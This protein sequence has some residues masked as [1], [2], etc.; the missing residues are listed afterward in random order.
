MKNIL[1]ISFLMALA[2]FCQGVSFVYGMD[3]A[4]GTENKALIAPVKDRDGKSVAK[5][6]EA[7]L[8]DAS[9]LVGIGVPEQ[10]P[11][12]PLNLALV[13]TDSSASVPAGSDGSARTTRSG[14]LLNSTRQQR[15]SVSQTLQTPKGENSGSQEGEVTAG[16]DF[17][18]MAE[19]NRLVAQNGHNGVQVT[20]TQ[21]ATQQ[22][23]DYNSD[24]WRRE[25]DS[26]RKKTRATVRDFFTEDGG[27]VTAGSENKASTALD[28][29]RGQQVRLLAIPEDSQ[30]TSPN[31]QRK[32]RR[33]THH[34]RRTPVAGAQQ[35]TQEVKMIALQDCPPPMSLEEICKHIR[36]QGQPKTQYACL[37]QAKNF[38]TIVLG[39]GQLKN[40]QGSMQLPQ[41]ALQALAIELAV[42]GEHSAQKLFDKAMIRLYL[43]YHLKYAV[44]KHMNQRGNNLALQP[45][46]I[47]RDMVDQIAGTQYQFQQLKF[48][49][50]DKAL[51]PC[52]IHVNSPKNACFHYIEGFKQQLPILLRDLGISVPLARLIINYI[53]G[54]NSDDQV[55]DILEAHYTCGNGPKINA[56]CAGKL[57]C[58][59]PFRL[60]D[61]KYAAEPDFAL[62]DIFCMQSGQLLQRLDEMIADKEE[63]VIS[64]GD[65][66]NLLSDVQ[67]VLTASKVL[68]EAFKNDENREVYDKKEAQ[69]KNS[70]DLVKYLPKAYQLFNAQLRHSSVWK[71]L[72][73][74]GVLIMQE[75]NKNQNFALLKQELND[76]FPIIEAVLK[77]YVFYHLK[78]FVLFHCSN[79]TKNYCKDVAQDIIGG[80][81]HNGIDVKQAL[82]QVNPHTKTKLMNLKFVIDN[83]EV[84]KI[85]G[86]ESTEPDLFDGGVDALLP[87]LERLHDAQAKPNT[88]IMASYLRGALDAKRFAAEREAAK[89]IAA[90]KGSHQAST[91][92][93]VQ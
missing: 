93:T 92:C 64:F 71:A 7:K 3:L 55:S 49:W 47:V 38:S 18:G 16:P 36:E 83:K 46:D 67:R 33:M 11:T 39:E 13:R 6:P 56:L 22:Q 45:T 77:L 90:G 40:I 25:V 31:D 44:L 86:T 78:T 66:K 59:S 80:I 74:T 20:V 81:N 89:A 41:A 52:V 19:H 79:G 70:Q 58:R 65:L 75:K 28:N 51:L 72:R 63:P 68:N 42:E 12:E 21:S 82:K 37:E 4:N 17:E 27:V 54:D 88:S 62:Q 29:K 10:A 60:Q 5:K 1:K 9:L 15:T 48:M 2:I 8:P 53:F 73:T 35:S 57:Q 69:E 84:I 23:P 43:F 32:M 26:R 76:K 24:S 87:M 14:G 85:V 50:D 34:K 91:I 61:I 30:A